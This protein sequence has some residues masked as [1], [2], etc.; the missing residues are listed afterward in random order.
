MKFKLY[1]GTPDNPDEPILKA[2]IDGDGELTIDAVDRSGNR[3][4]SGHIL[5]IT[6]AG[7]LFLCHG[8]NT[9]LGL[10]LDDNG[11]ICIAEETP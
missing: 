9:T 8:V 11:R 1:E 6:N 3:L 7:E 10:K 4:S 2:Y 5:R